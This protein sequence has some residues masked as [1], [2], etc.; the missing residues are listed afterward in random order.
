MLHRWLLRLALCLL[1]PVAGFAQT[2]DP[3][4]Y[5]LWR[6][7]ATRAGAAVDSGAGTNEVFE[8]LR[9]RIADFRAKF[10]AA[11]TANSERIATLQ[12]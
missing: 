1:L 10:A 12:E 4:N 9:I 2:A 3:I 6:S 11:R 7:V 5:D 8:T